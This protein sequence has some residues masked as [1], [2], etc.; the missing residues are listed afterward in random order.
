MLDEIL[1]YR[2]YT[3]DPAEIT[4]ARLKY[5]NLKRSLSGLSRAMH[6][7]ARG[8]MNREFA[9]LSP[10]E[11]FERTK[12]VLRQ[13]T[14][15]YKPDKTKADDGFDVQ[16]WF[17]L[18]IKECKKIFYPEQAEKFGKI[19]EELCKSCSS[20]KS[21]EFF[22]P[23]EGKN[24]ENKI[25]YEKVIHEAGRAGKLVCRYLVSKKPV[26][27]EDIAIFTGKKEKGLLETQFD[28]MLKIIAAYLLEDPKRN[29]RFDPQL[30]YARICWADIV[31]WSMIEKKDSGIMQQF[32]WNK[33][34]IFEREISEIRRNHTRIRL[35][36]D[37]M[38]E[39]R[40][41]L[42]DSEELAVFSKEHPGY[43]VYIDEGAM[44]PLKACI[45][46]DDGCLAVY[47]S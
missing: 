26:W 32:R 4:V 19:L 44:R 47:N 5:G 35:N 13:W 2:Q 3:E 34:P 12:K 28:L 16:D 9:D 8:Y 20:F 42:I 39:Y 38:E 24:T 33:R 14:G 46:Q 23:E 36:R 27:P 18:Y 6:I 10:D 45:V 25:S 1:E 22:I 43:G 30:R 11:T 41:N 37:F 15:E 17:P 31:N 29:C 21:A 7:V 40:W